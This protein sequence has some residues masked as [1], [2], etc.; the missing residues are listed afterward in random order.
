MLTPSE[1]GGFAPAHRISLEHVFVQGADTAC[2]TTAAAAEAVV[3]AFAG[4]RPPAAQT[5]PP[6]GAGVAL[7]TFSGCAFGAVHV[8][9]L[10]RGCFGV[11]CH[12]CVRPSA[13]LLHLTPNSG[14]RSAALLEMPR[15][16]LTVHHGWRHVRLAWL[17]T[18]RRG[19]A[20]QADDEQDQRANNHPQPWPLSPIRS[21]IAVDAVSHAPSSAYS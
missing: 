18:I 15:H 5:G 1:G 6:D 11:S 19:E 7:G 21:I 20:D 4:E 12:C 2:R 13:K 10:A 16:D 3:D 14:R 8:G 17:N 9:A